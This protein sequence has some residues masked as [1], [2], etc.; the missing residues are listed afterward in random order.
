MNTFAVS[1][2]VVVQQ[3]AQHLDPASTKHLEIH[4]NFPVAMLLGV[5]YGATLGGV[6]TLIGTPPNTLLAAFVEERYGVT[7]GFGQWMLV[8]LPMTIGLLPLCWWLLTQR[9]YPVGFETRGRTLEHL[10]SLRRE[11]GSMSSAERRVAILFLLLALGWMSRKLL[12]TLPLL[13]GLSDAGIAMIMAVALFLVPSGDLKSPPLMD[14]QATRDLP[15]GILILFGGGLSLAAAVS[16]TGLAAWLGQRILS[17]GIAELSVL[18]MVIATSII[19]LTE[20]TSNL[21]TTATFLP[22]VAGVA[23]E[24]GH[25]PIALLAPVAMAASCAFML[26]VA[27]PPNAVVYG[28][29]RI[30]IPD[31]V[32]AGFWLNIAS[33]LVVS[34]IAVYLAPRLLG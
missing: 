11:L 7:I 33:I 12:M 3:N 27:T 1:V 14:W 30:S 8:G 2:I 28:S 20:M 24:A 23:A 16:N 18:V 5:A 22:V 6:A 25:T 19:F 10:K 4:Q 17:L 31:M 13:S 21:A 29:G 34:L 32:K 15:W 26:P 9:L